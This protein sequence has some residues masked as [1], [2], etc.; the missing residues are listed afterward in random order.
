[1][2]HW[3]NIVGAFFTKEKYPLGSKILTDT[4][5]IKVLCEFDL[6]AEAIAD[7]L[8]ARSVTNSLIHS[9][10]II[11]DADWGYALKAP[12]DE[13]RPSIMITDNRC[14][15]Y[16]EDLWDRGATALMTGNDFTMNDL[17]ALILRADKHFQSGK[18]IKN[19]P[20]YKT[21]LTRKERAIFLASVQNAGIE[22]KK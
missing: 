6:L 14:P 10:D 20:Y 18:R 1:M 7:S 21:E 9:V 19:T 17:T 8:K 16:W 12:L 4:P 3:K 15:E 22:N 11:F 5:K 13:N 2:W